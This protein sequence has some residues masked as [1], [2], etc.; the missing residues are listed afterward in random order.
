MIAERKNKIYPYRRRRKIIWILHEIKQKFPFWNHDD[1]WWW[2]FFFVCFDDDD[3][4]GDDQRY[5]DYDNEDD[6][7][8]VKRLKNV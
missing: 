3:D 6:E 2:S 7:D 1:G 5:S 4:D 8:F